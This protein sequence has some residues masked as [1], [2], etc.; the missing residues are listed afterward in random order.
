MSRTAKPLDRMT[1]PIVTE[2][3]LP[4]EPVVR[5]PFIDDV[6]VPPVDASPLPEP[7]RRRIWD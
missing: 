6:T 4:P 5:D 1:Q 3:S 7:Q 2:I